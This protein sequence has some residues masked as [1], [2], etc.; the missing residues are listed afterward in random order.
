MSKALKTALGATD[1][2][3]AQQA[4]QTVMTSILLAHS[5]R[6]ALL[7][8]IA[9]LAIC[10]LVMMLGT[11]GHASP[12]GGA[13]LPV[14]E[15]L[16]PTNSAIFSTLDEVPIVLRAAAPNDVF[17][18]ASVFANQ[19]Q[20]ATVSYCCALCPCARPL[21]GEETILQIPVPWNGGSPPPRTWQGW[22][23][24]SAR[25]YRLTA[26]ATGENG[27]VVEAVPVT[28]TVIDRALRIFVRSDGTVTLV[29]PEGSGGKPRPAQVDASGS[30]STR[31]RSGVLFR[32]AAGKRTGTKILPLGVR[33]S[34]CSVTLATAVPVLRKDEFHESL[35]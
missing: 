22:T 16:E 5:K 1:P 14:I 25:S 7:S 18:T 12:L 32:R 6:L 2:A 31:G 23:N 29:I 15:F 19:I 34:T 21:P 24:V 13:Q 26:R 20:I 11:P 8:L 30:L 33:S 4:P 3:S 35:F 28:I 10:L 9:A 17:L 27:G